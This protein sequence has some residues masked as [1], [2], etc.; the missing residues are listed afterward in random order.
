VAGIL[1]AA[2]LRAIQGRKAKDTTR[3]KMRLLV[4]GSSRTAGTARAPAADDASPEYWRC[5]R[6]SK[7]EDRV[8]SV[9]SVMYGGPRK[10]FRYRGKDYRQPED[11][12]TVSDGVK[13]FVGRRSGH[14]DM[15]MA[16]SDQPP[17]FNR[18][19]SSCH[20]RDGRVLWLEAVLRVWGMSR[21]CSI[22]IPQSRVTPYFS[23]HMKF[24]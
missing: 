18:V 23:N 16:C 19:P 5:Q 7:F 14:V 4:G 10:V 22:L 13:V 6:N 9:P 24:A 2:R 12:T 15:V 17:C 8:Y 21:D 11:I 1:K 20:I 3:R